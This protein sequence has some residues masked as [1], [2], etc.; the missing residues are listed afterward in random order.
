MVMRLYER[1][2]EDEG[3]YQLVEKYWHDLV[4]RAAA[5]SG[6][7]GEW[8]R[9]IPRTTPNGTP[10]ERDGNP[11]ADGRSQRLN[12]GFRI[13]QHR[14]SEDEIEISAW[15]KA[16]EEEFTD[17]PRDELVINL[18]LS[19]ESSRLAERLLREW[20]TPAVSPTEM[21]A[22]IFKALPRAKDPL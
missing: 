17:L 6:Q 1:F 16:Y 12:R 13:I 11:I 22:F 20:M 9:W 5:S 21:A 19:E 15:L 8:L 18:S 7:A 10:V 4:E 14:A 2:L 3:E